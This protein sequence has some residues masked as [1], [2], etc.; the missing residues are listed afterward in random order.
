M[1]TSAGKGAGALVPVDGALVTVLPQPEIT[2]LVIV[3]TVS[4]AV[5][6]KWRLMSVS[7]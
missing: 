4:T 1:S 3:A 5:L 2:T 7:R 6:R